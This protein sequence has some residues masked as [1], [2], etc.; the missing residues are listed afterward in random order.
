[1]NGGHDVGPFSRK[2]QLQRLLENVGDSGD[3]LKDAV[4]GGK[5]AKAGLVAAGLATA[6]AASAAVSS[7]RRR[8]EGES[9][10]S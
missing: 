4:P 5:A 3:A 9:D 1:V 8:G 2:S 7:I 10:D 6:T